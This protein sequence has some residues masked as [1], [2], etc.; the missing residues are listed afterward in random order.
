[1]VEEQFNDGFYNN[2]LNYWDMQF[3]SSL[4]ATCF[5]QQFKD[6][7]YKKKKKIFKF[8]LQAWHYESIL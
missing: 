3:C 8:H 6:V 7:K 4:V 2:P 1:M 5:Q